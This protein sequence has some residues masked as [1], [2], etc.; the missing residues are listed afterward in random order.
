MKLLHR[1]SS[2][3]GRLGSMWLRMGPY[4]VRMKRTTFRN[5]SK[6]LQD[7]SDLKKIEKSRE[8]PKSRN[9]IHSR[10]F[11]KWWLPIIPEV[12]AAYCS[13][14]WG[15]ARSGRMWL[16]LAGSSKPICLTFD[17]GSLRVV[18]DLK[19]KPLPARSARIQPDPAR[20]GRI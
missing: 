12:V 17:Q 2:I 7:L 10:L 19:V 14:R 13:R 18:S 1:E 3:S 8:F 5:L 9:S 4:S 20:S 16:E 15:L 6:P 11:L